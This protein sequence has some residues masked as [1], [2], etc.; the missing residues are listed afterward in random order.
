MTVFLY[1]FFPTNKVYNCFTLLYKNFKKFT[2]VLKKWQDF[3]KTFLK[4]L[5]DILKVFT[6]FNT[7]CKT[8]KIDSKCFMK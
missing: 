8:F 5:Q 6:S 1:Y 3:Y 4:V 2:R 7:D